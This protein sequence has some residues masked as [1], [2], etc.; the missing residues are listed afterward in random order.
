MKIWNVYL[1]TFEK[2][3]VTRFVCSVRASSEPV[4]KLRQLKK[5]H[6]GMYEGSWSLFARLAE[7]DHWQNRCKVLPVSNFDQPWSNES[8]LTNSLVS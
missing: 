3:S 8:V 2:G 4:A 1:V 6:S 5:Q 7:T